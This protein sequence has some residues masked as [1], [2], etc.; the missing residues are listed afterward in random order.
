MRVWPSGSLRSH[1]SAIRFVF[2]IASR[3]VREER[4]H[5]RGGLQEEVVGLELE[6]AGRVQVGR[7]AHAQQ[8]VVGRRLLAPDVVQVVRDDER[9]ADL[10]S[11]TQEL[12]V[13]PPL[14]G[15]PVVLELEEEAALPEDLAVLAGDR[16][17]E[18][19]VVDLEGAR[20]LAVQARRQP[21]QALAVL[22]QVLA[23]DARLVVVAVDVGVGD[24]PAQ[25]AVAGQVA[26]PGG[27]GGRAGCPPCLP[28]RSSTGGRRTSRRR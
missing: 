28:C 26:S 23:V 17:G 5:L 15:Q 7:R 3:L 20:D 16:A 4:G 18:I 14:L 24:E 22:R 25:V 10:G 27:S 6:P 8:H 19:P 2:V 21:D 1:I 13:E 12:L 11:E 9:Q